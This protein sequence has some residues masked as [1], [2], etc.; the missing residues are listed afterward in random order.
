MAQVLYRKWRPQ[1]LEE[2]VGQEPIVQ[3]LLHALEQGKVG[4]AYLFSGPRGTGKTSTGRILAKAL[5]CE[6]SKGRGEPCNRCDNCLAVNQGAFLDLVEIDAASNRGIEEI[7]DLREKVRFAPAR[8]RV[9]VYIIDEVHMLTDQAF[10]AL[11][12][13]LEEPPGHVVFILAT[14]EV[15]K[16]PLTIVSRCQ[17]FD[18]RRIGIPEVVGL[19]EKICRSEGYAVTPEALHVIARAAQ[20]SLRD[21]ENLLEHLVLSVGPRATGREAEELLGASGS[22]RAREL[23]KRLLASDLSGALTSV[24]RLQAEGV[25]L[26]QVHRELV[27]E[28]RALLLIAAGAESALD[29]TATELAER[30]ELAS[31]SEVRSLQR[32]LERLAPVVVTSGGSPLP[33]E[34][35]F[36]GIVEQEKSDAA[37]PLP[38]MPKPR[39]ASR[40]RETASQ[41]SASASRGEGDTRSK[42]S[43]PVPSGAREEKGDMAPPPVPTSPTTQE[44]PTGASD[45]APIGEVDLPMVQ[46]RWREIVDSLKGMGSN[47]N[48]DAILRSASKPIALED[49][50]LVLGFYYPFHKEKV[51]DP[52]YRHLVE[53]RISQKLGKRLRLRCEL[54]PRPSQGGHL[55]RAALERG[56]ER[57][58][59]E[60]DTR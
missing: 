25:D 24:A 13:T 40:G 35:A 31:S 17:R 57:A 2:V 60:G 37:P 23:A 10:N 38:E 58:S 47:R 42:P 12:K 46:S 28:L 55:V 11:L 15:H 56:A 52:K 41:P 34:L 48:L 32:A 26:K 49:E 51:E 44:V 20:G 6:E 29:M 39:S 14:T 30:R 8:G 9:K 3:T 50:T 5:D 36:V 18:F 33:L 27:E 1:R 59:E 21:A 43:S 22:D 16:V 4:H 19:L 54:I 45:S 7:R 53:Q